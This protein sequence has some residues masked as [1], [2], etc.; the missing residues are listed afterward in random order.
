MSAP[1][2]RRRY[3]TAGSRRG[4]VY[5]FQLVAVSALYVGQRVYTGHKQVR[6]DSLQQALAAQTAL[7]DSLRARRDSLA[8]L[9]AISVRAADLGLHPARLAQLARLP[10]SAP[11]L[12]GS[13]YAQP[14]EPFQMAGAMNRLWQWLD[15]AT[16][17]TQEA[18][19]AR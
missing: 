13:G 14:A 6:I 16:P 19:A 17:R 5:L 4:L 3:R 15:G 7:A 10:L 2:L 8:S 11:V 9:T 18:Q 12:P 1:H